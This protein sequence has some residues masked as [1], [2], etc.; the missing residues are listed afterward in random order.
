[1]KF[2]LL[3]KTLTLFRP[4]ILVLG[5][6]VA[7]LAFLAGLAGFMPYFP[8]ILLGGIVCIAM[9]IVWLE[10]PV[11]AL[12][13]PLI[14]VFLPVGLIPANIHSILN[15][16]LTVIA[17]GVW[18]IWLLT[19]RKK[20]TWTIPAL[21]M[22]LFLG[23][24]G[25]TVLWAARV[26]NAATALQV[27]SLRFLL[28]LFLIPNEI[29]TKQDL[30]G[31]MN[32]LAVSGWVLLLSFVATV[33]FNGYEVGTQLAIFGGNQNEAGVL[34]VLAMVG[35]IWQVS[36]YAKSYRIFGILM[37]TT[38]FLL[39]FGLVVMT[40]SRGSALSM[41]FT[42]LA[43]WF[44]KP[45]RVWGK[46]VLSVLIL[47][48]ILTPSIFTTLVLR[49]LAEG[50]DTLLGGREMLWK[51]AWHMIQDHPTGGVGIG[52]S[53]YAILPYL[54]NDVHMV[55]FQSAVVHNPILTIWS[56][57]GFLGILL[58][59]GMLISSFYL[60]VSQYLKFRK[61]GC[62]D[63]DPYFAAVSSVALGYL[64]SWFKG[65]GMESDFSYF[66]VLALL[67]LPSVLNY[68][69]FKCIPAVS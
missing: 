60:F 38:F 2:V 53:P 12:Y 63:I 61:I 29:R 37:G 21:F 67:I 69:S 27:Y 64:I 62:K 43:F 28:F 56:E 59:L 45:T 32:T 57:T 19:S 33:L 54:E 50:N 66:F 51:A 25:I 41:M 24:G 36:H 14:L 18:F 23:W 46:V 39:T 9:L 65:G 22:F 52:N 42:T 34:A 40:G 35:V 20:I 4:G 68:T 47:A 49:F 11:C 31:L 17:A 3:F 7:V 6:L 55:L 16:L 58:Y 1:M 48:V 26:S 30:D 5:T 8:L 44:W 13:A 10:K 15:R